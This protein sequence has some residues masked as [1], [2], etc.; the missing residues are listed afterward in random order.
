MAENGVLERK[1]RLIN[2]LI[3]LWQE[4]QVE[5][6]D[7]LECPEI[8]D[9]MED[10][11]MG[12]KTKIAQRK[13]LAKEMIGSEFSCNGAIVKVLLGVPTLDLLKRQSPIIIANL[14]N[15]WHD[16]YIALNQLSGSLKIQLSEES[17][18]E[19]KKGG[20]LLGRLFGRS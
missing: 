3:V 17:K 5:I 12:T 8:D 4:L 13:Q 19:K 20:S 2:E 15:V 18:G 14:R 16:A 6:D 1:I 9:E 11:C 10:R 7:S